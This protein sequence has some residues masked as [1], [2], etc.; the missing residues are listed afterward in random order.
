MMYGPLGLWPT[1]DLSSLGLSALVTYRARNTT[2]H[3]E[4]EA[5]KARDW[6]GTETII[7]A[8]ELLVAHAQL[9]LKSTMK[10]AQMT[11]AH[12]DKHDFTKVEHLILPWRSSS[13]PA[14]LLVIYPHLGL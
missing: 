14:K 11:E 5:T 12:A 3:D 8:P 10:E 1:H 4:T 2:S 9:V 6:C 7:M 13:F